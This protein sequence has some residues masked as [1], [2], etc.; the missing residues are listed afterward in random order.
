[1][2]GNLK[3]KILPQAF[4]VNYSSI[5]PNIFQKLQLQKP[6]KFL[7]T[8]KLTEKL[9]LRATSWTRLM[10]DFNTSLVS[11]SKKLKFILV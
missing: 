1:M 11:A 2:T 7:I 4:S 6:Q 10:A 3:A 8:S 9:R 5:T